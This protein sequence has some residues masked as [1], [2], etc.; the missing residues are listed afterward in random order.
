ME[1]FRLFQRFVW[2]RYTT[3]DRCEIR[4]EFFKAL[5][6]EPST[7]STAA[8]SHFTYFYDFTMRWRRGPCPNIFDADDLNEFS[9]RENPQYGDYC[10]G[11]L[12]V[13]FGYQDSLLQGLQ[14]F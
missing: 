5:L 12:K 3:G 7:S 1:R 6:A 14:M 11:L 13:K 2:E 10:L 8:G 4:P 9:Y